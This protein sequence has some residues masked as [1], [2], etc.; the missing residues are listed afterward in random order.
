MKNPLPAALGTCIIFLCLLACGHADAG[1]YYSRASGPWTSSSTWSLTSGGAAIASGYPGAGDN[2]IIEG[3]FTVTIAAAGV[4]NLSAANVTIGGSTTSGTLSFPNGNPPSTLTVTGDVTIG[5]TGAS[6][7]GTLSYGSWGLTITCARLLKGAGSASRVNPLQQ[8]F[9]FTGSFTLPAAFNAFRNFIINGGTVALSAD[10][11]TN[12][13]VSPDIKAGSTLDLGTYVMTIGG[14]QNFIINGTLIVGGNTGGF[15]NSNFPNTFESLT[16]G[17]ASTVVYSYAGSQTI[18]PTTYGNLTLSGSGT[19]TTGYLGYVSGLT[20]TSGGSGYSCDATISFV[21][22]GGSGATADGYNFGDPG[23]PISYLDLTDGGSGYTSAP[24]VVITGDCGGSGA[25]ATATI[26]T[27][28]VATVNG[29]LRITGS[30]AL[31]GNAP[32]FAAGST[33]EYAGTA[34]QTTGAEFP[35]TWSGSGGVII[36]NSNG[37]T[38]NSSKSIGSSLTLTSGVLTTS[39]S[40]LLTITNT[41]T[42]AI[43]GGSATSFINGPVA[44]TLPSNLASGSSYTIPLGKGAAYL[45]LVLVNPTTGAG[46]VTAT[47]QAFNASSGG[48]AD[49]SSLLSISGTQYWSL[50]TSGNFNGTSVSLTRTAALSGLD[51]IGKSATANGV[52]TSLGGSVSGSSIVNSA[53]TGAVTG[54]FL[55]M[56][57]DALLLPATWSPLDARG[58]QDGIR[59]SWTVFTETD[60][61]SYDIEKSIDGLYY[62]PAASLPSKGNSVAA[63]GYSWLDSNPATGNNYYRVKAI[64][65]DG[66]TKYSN[67]AKVGIAPKTTG[68]HV[69]PNPIR[70]NTIRLGLTNMERGVYAVTITD[71]AG[72]PVFHT[73]ISH[74]GGAAVYML[75][76][77]GRLSPGVYRLQLD[78]RVVRAQATLLVED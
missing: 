30:A 74:T 14:Y 38:L 53:N 2:V 20:L 27:A 40:H 75:R 16:I 73:T 45:P 56:A 54:L 9:T 72:Q 63:V 51:L 24:T 70:E 77:A 4:E 29:A 64:G 41:A 66:D 59:V 62:Y 37:V 3:G 31:S 50:A 26:T 48:S 19:K 28:S 49:G 67:V 6:A 21:G 15:S 44:I 65:R 68:L 42:T 13:S 35:A 32:V 23:D 25:T 7:A 17:S 8:D 55:V 58:Q 22:G 71:M 76:P 34:A 60:M 61:S 36:N 5:G 1:T 12:G 11:S 46:A 52:Y 18:Y 39:A 10:I 47:V 69:Y 78:G 33:L 57:S 43:S